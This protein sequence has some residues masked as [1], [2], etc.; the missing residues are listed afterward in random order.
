VG[1]G[2]RLGHVWQLG[3]HRGAGWSDWDSF[4]HSVRGTPAAVSAV[5]GRLYVFAVGLDGSI[6][7]I[8]QRGP[9]DGGGWCDWE[10]FDPILYGRC[11]SAPRG[12]PHPSRQ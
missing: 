8:H 2:G 5:D 1:T 11:L 12:A 6:G 9:N 3:T 4:G 10:R 7:H